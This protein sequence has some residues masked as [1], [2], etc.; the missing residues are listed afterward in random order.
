MADIPEQSPAPIEIER[1]AS[2]APTDVS[3]ISLDYECDHDASSLEEQLQEEQYVISGF[4][5]ESPVNMLN[6][7]PYRGISLGTLHRELALSDTAVRARSRHFTGYGLSR[8]TADTIECASHDVPD[9]TM[10]DSSH[11]LGHSG[12]T[13]QASLGAGSIYTPELI[14]AFQCLYAKMGQQVLVLRIRLSMHVH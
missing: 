7:L 8:H 6:S 13:A 2:P 14:H 9:A 4:K 11:A 12:A 5:S 3:D 10:V 1:Q